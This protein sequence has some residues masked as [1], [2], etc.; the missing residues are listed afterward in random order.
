MDIFVIASIAYIFLCAAGG[1]ASFL[2]N[3]A[4]VEKLNSRLPETEQFPILG[5]HFGKQ[6]RF[7]RAYRAA[8][9]H[10]RLRS[11]RNRMYVVLAAALLLCGA[12]LLF[13]PHR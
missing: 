3:F 7:E 5:W 4:M 12:T 2:L 1:I 6:L 8:F 10:D 11:W 13:W 9:P